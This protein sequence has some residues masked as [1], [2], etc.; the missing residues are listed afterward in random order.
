MFSSMPIRVLQVVNHMDYGG[1]ESVI[2]NY[3][4]H[5]DRRKIQFDFAVSEDSLLPQKEEIREL[6]GKIFLLPKIIQLKKYLSALKKIIRENQYQIVHCNMSSLS[7]IPLYAAYQEKASIRICHNHTTTHKKEGIKVVMKCML[8]PYCKWFATDYFACGEY[9]GQWL[10]GV[11]CLHKGGIYIM[12]NAVE[13]EKF[14][15]H[16]DTRNKIRKKLGLDGKFV[17]GHIGRFVTPK[18]H[19]FLVDIFHKVYLQNPDA[20]LLLVGEGELLEKTQNKVKKLGLD[21]AVIFYG[22]SKDTASLYQVMDVFCLP[23]LFEGFP[24]V[25]VEAQTGG[26]PV[27]VSTQVPKETKLLDSYDSLTLKESPE[28]WAE[29]ILESYSKENQREQAYLKVIEAGYSIKEEAE[30]LLE[31]Y[32][33]AGRRKDGW[34]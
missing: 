25:L 13:I 21:K 24:V 6:G 5:I 18:N 11:H 15:Y 26:L 23:S 14:R 32:F 2:M 17:V 12:R 28:V 9:A 22:N 16:A 34:K 3:Y 7:V 19:V 1:V 31:F 20:R 4:R 8:R 10:F 30:R 27:I 29:R 33:K